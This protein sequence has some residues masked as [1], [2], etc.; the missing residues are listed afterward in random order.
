MQSLIF[1]SPV[2]Y[3]RSLFDS[4]SLQKIKDKNMA[5][6]FRG[7]AQSSPF[8]QAVEKATDANQPNED[9]GLIMRICDHVSAHDE[10]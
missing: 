4:F 1:L 5:S 8:Q 10:R 7:P 9:W 3:I 2:G 6:F